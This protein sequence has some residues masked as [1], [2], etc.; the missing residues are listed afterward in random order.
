MGLTIVMGIGL[1]LRQLLY[2][3]SLW[4][5]EAKLALQIAHRSFLDFFEPSTYSEIVIIASEQDPASWLSR[6]QWQIA[7]PL[8]LCASKALVSLFG[9]CEWVYRLVPFL[10]G[11]A[12]MVLFYWLAKRFVRG[13][14]VLLPLLLLAVGNKMVYYSAE[15]KQ[16]SMDVVAFLIISLVTL[17]YTEHARRSAWCGLLLAGIVAPWFSHAALFVLPVSGMYCLYRTAE[18]GM[19]REWPRLILV[20]FLWTAS[21]GVLYMLCMRSARSAQGLLEFHGASFMPLSCEV[22]VWLVAAFRQML[23][24]PLSLSRPGAW[25]L[26]VMPTCLIAVGLMAAPRMRGAILLW[27]PILLALLVSALKLYPFHTRL[28]L[29]LTPAFYLFL[30]IGCQHLVGL[31]AAVSRSGSRILAALG[32]GIV[33][34]YPVAYSAYRLVFP[35]DREDVRSAMDYIGARWSEGDRIILDE[36]AREAFIFYNRKRWGALDVIVVDPS[37]SVQL[38]DAVSHC[39]RGAW[40]IQVYSEQAERQRA[41]DEVMHLNLFTPEVSFSGS[42]VFRGLRAPAGTSGHGGVP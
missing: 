33:L 40:M 18:V 28:I 36:H 6:S 9:A 13:A 30:G 37:N 21:V 25:Y 42:H 31:S 15:V 11:A 29:Y 1:R 10:A 5:D 2:N 39:P 4:L 22:P 7:G 27:G 34:A 38:S 16:Y 3:R 41:F 8:Y 14:F 35:Y 19:R 20:G 32:C 12:S 24:D 23:Y 17:R 26:E